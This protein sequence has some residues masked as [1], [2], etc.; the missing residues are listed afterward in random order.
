MGTKSAKCAKKQKAQMR[1]V[2]EVPALT[3]L[4]QGVVSA[5]KQESELFATKLRGTTQSTAVN[6]GSDIQKSG[7]HTGRLNERYGQARLQKCRAQYVA[8]LTQRVITRTTP[9]RWK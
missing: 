9:N 4:K 8:G 6:L 1:F 2:S 5:I 3:G 7:L